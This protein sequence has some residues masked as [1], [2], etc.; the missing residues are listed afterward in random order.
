MDLMTQP[1]GVAAALAALVGLFAL[2][3]RWWRGR[4]RTAAR[5][6]VQPRDDARAAAST[7][8]ARG[9]QSA[10]AVSGIPPGADTDDATA[11]LLRRSRGE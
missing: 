8:T 3:R 2:A 1:S 6:P 10:D 11:A 5:A 4:E 7:A 9:Q